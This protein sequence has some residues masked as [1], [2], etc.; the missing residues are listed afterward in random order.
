MITFASAVDCGDF[1]QIRDH[2]AQDRLRLMWWRVTKVEVTRATERLELINRHGQT[3]HYS[4]Q[5]VKVNKWAPGEDNRD[6]I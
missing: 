2:R 3:A 5:H 4:G 6:Q 1:I